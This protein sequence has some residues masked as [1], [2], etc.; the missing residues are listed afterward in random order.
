[1][2]DLFSHPSDGAG[3]GFDQSG[4]T[5]KS[6]GARAVHTRAV[7]VPDMGVYRVK[8]QLDAD[9][10]LF[11]QRR[12]LI[13]TNAHAGE[14]TFL[15]CLTEY[16][17][18]MQ[19][20]LHRDK[21]LFASSFGGSIT[22]M[23]AEQ[24]QARRVFVA[25]DSTVADQYAARE[26]YPFDCYAGWGQMLSCFLKKDAICNMAHSGL[27]A[28]CFQ[29]DGHFDIVKRYMQ[30]G[31]LLLIQ[32]GHND[33]KR[34]E[35]QAHRL[36]CAYLEALADA[37]L[38]CG[39]QPV[40]ISPVSRVPSHD[41]AGAFDLLKAHA[42]AVGELANKRRIPFIDLHT[43]SFEEYCR[44]GERCRDLFKD[45]T[46]ANDP[47]AFA[48]ARE[49]A[50]CLSAMGLAEWTVVDAGCLKSDRAR[51][52]HSSVPAPLPV[53]YIDTQDVEDQTVLYEG[54]QN[55]RLDPCVLHMHPFEPLSRMG[56]VQKLFR[57]AGLG[58]E[59]TDGI[60]PYRDIDAR[61]FDASCAAACKKHGLIDGDTLRPDDMI[62]VLEINDLCARLGCTARL[63]ESD[64][65]PDRYQITKL[66]NQIRAER[67]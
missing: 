38:A 2:A 10:V 53:P 49:V 41:A 63:N 46:H 7:T 22:A 48:L 44:M 5:G 37:A 42:E 15:T 20:A 29:E 32:F 19:N 18:S 11:G 17:P 8:V 54:V 12:N 39:A 30:K 60:A 59:A 1:M 28:R 66:L 35:L 33:Q 36:Y 24:T 51:S 23:S 31:D 40:L 27:T 26:Y 67:K 3:H 21:T 34:R 55:G 45:M 16:I 9:A 56:F 6:E 50:R 62:T 13:D 61:E 14:N 52:S 64:A 43:Y 25:G 47:G 4:W 57:A 65:L 58:G